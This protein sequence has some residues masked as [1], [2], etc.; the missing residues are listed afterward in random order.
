MASRKIDVNMCIITSLAERLTLL[1]LTDADDLEEVLR[2]WDRATNRQKK[3]E[4]GSNKYRQKTTNTAPP[5]RSKLLTPDLTSPQKLS[6]SNE[7]ATPKVAKES[8]NLDPR[9]PDRDHGHQDHNS[10][11]HHNGC[12][13]AIDARIVD[14]GSTR[15]S[16]AGGVL[17]ARSAVKE[18]IRRIIAFWCAEDVESFMTW[19][20]KSV[21]QVSKR[22]DLHGNTCDLHGKHT[23]TISSLRQVDEYAR[24]EVIMRVDLQ[25]VE[26]RGYW[27][28]QDPDLWFKPRDHEVTSESKRHSEIT[29]FR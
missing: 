4:F 10:K 8:T 20:N 18:D 25:P 22:P 27:I 16:F 17:R 24:S 21:D 11:T 5:L 3:A 29:E 1:R 23:F 26:S 12:L 2:A 15:I 28:Q 7:G 19:E 14:P 13:T 9:L 6:C